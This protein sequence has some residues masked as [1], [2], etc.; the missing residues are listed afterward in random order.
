[1]KKGT[2][3]LVAEANAEVRTLTLEQAFA[4]LG[5]PGVVFVD[6][7][8]AEELVEYGKIPGAEHHPRG[9]L[10]F[11]ADPE[12]K[13]HRPVFASG[14]LLVLYCGSGGRSALATK[15]LQDMGLPDVAQIEGGI[16]AWIAASLPV[17]RT[18]Q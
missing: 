13:F 12:H 10:E 15:A 4:L 9:L 7:R 14:K 6:L 2:K 8:E 11:Y 3:Q 17:E 18:P 5:K 16:K 1:V